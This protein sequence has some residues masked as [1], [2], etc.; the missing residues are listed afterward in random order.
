MMSWAKIKG[1]FTLPRRNVVRIIAVFAAANPRSPPAITLIVTKVGV[2][3]AYAEIL[4]LDMDIVDGI[5]PH[6]MSVMSTYT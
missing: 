2:G 1:V 3:V 6:S 4:H 5:R